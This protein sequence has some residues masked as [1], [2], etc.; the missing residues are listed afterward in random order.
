MTAG[1]KIAALIQNFQQQPQQ[2]VPA[3]AT[4][5]VFEP[6]KKASEEPVPP[7][8]EIPFAEEQQPTRINPVNPE[9]PINAEKTSPVESSTPTLVINQE[10]STIASAQVY[11]DS[12][13]ARLEELVFKF[14]RL[15]DRVQN[16]Q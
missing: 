11:S 5:K 4:Q 8:Q 9:K 2:P 6:P 16:I 15:A 14:E 13:L 10:N 1:K 7:T 12:E 3:R